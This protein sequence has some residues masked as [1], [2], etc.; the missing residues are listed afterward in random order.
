MWICAVDFQ[1]AFDS[2]K[3]EAIWEAL[4]ECVVNEGYIE[5]L[6][7]L[8]SE[9]KGVVKFQVQSEEFKIERGTKQG[10]PV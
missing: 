2:V 7:R 3:F 5:L 10:D 8:Y 9:Q 4:K 1:K 6:S